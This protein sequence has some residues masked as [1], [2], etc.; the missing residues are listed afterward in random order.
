MSFDD[1]KKEMD[2]KLIELVDNLDVHVNA[3][4]KKKDMEKL[5]SMEDPMRNL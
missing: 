2:S 1:V 5:K 4:C 3:L